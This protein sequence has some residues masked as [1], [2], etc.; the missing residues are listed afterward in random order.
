MD[1]IIAGHVSRPVNVVT[2]TLRALTESDHS[3]ALLLLRTRSDENRTHADAWAAAARS[4]SDLVAVIE[5]DVII[6]SHFESNAIQAFSRLPH[7]T[8]T[9]LSAFRP[10][11][12]DRLDAFRALGPNLVPKGLKWWGAQALI[13]TPSLASLIAEILDRH[14][15]VHPYQADP[16]RRGRSTHDAILYDQLPTHRCDVAV[17]TPSLAEHQVTPSLVG[18]PLHNTDYYYVGETFSPDWTYP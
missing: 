7:P 17:H 15:D 10:A 5:D 8:T 18:S 11:V 16:R 4:T 14:C 12:A 1:I 2:Q 9:L 3:G 13:A 6:G